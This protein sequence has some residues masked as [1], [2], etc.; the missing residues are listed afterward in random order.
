MNRR[1]VSCILIAILA[2]FIAFSGCTSPSVTPAV[3]Q[4][5]QPTTIQTLP[6]ATAVPVI[7][8]TVKETITKTETSTDVEKVILHDKGLLS[9]TSY[10]SYDF[11][12]MGDEFSQIGVKYKITIKAEKP[13]IGYAVTSL[14]TDQL[15]GS[16]FIPQYVPYSEKIQW[17]LIVPY[18]EM[19]K[20]TDA[21]KTFTVDKIAPYAYVLDGR[22]MGFD[23]LYKSTPPFNYEI[24][25]TKIYNPHTTPV[26]LY[27]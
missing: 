11:K 15:K 8:Q 21:T 14:Q 24:T 12:A 1:I 7:T 18:M 9:P 20:V 26:V 2:V 3:P 22:W 16:E 13:V 5:Y 4:T 19:G 10:K 27:Q 6:P 23:D 25:I 17:G